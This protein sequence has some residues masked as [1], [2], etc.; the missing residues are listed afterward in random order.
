MEL[1]SDFELSRP[2]VTQ[3]GPSRCWVVFL[4]FPY[5]PWKWPDS[6]SRGMTTQGRLDCNFRLA[7]IV[8]LYASFHRH[9]NAFHGLCYTSRWALSG[10]KNNSMGPPWRIDPTIHRSYHGTTCLSSSILLRPYNCTCLGQRNRRRPVP[11]PVTGVHYNSLLFPLNTLTWPDR[12]VVA[13][14]TQHNS[15]KTKNGYLAFFHILF[16]KHV[17]PMC[18]FPR[19]SLLR[20]ILSCM[21]RDLILSPGSIT[22]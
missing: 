12:T 11:V 6:C 2:K 15:F 22:E 17:R 13:S 8:L 3:I 19:L 21:Y 14:A 1:R 5:E 18:L 9:D 7:A 16:S 10:R 4:G 20:V